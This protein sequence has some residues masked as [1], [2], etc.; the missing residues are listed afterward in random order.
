MRQRR[1]EREDREDQSRGEQDELAPET[2]S[3][4]SR[5][6]RA[7]HQ[8]EETCDENGGEGRHR[9]A[10]FLHDY[11]RGEIDRAIVETVEGDKH[12]TPYRHHPLGSAETSAIDDLRHVDGL[13]RRHDRS[14]LIAAGWLI[15]LIVARVKNFSSLIRAQL[16]PWKIA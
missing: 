3:E 8:P 15:L 9:N 11:G 5:A 12:K 16:R 10:P 2:V 1:R 13:S 7:D 4:R 14:S 6:E